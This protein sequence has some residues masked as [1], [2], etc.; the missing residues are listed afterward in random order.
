MFYNT[1]Y[2]ILFQSV[3]GENKDAEFSN[4]AVTTSN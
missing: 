4:T 2:S 1:F 3:F